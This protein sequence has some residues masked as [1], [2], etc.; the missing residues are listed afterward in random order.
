ML[1]E[2]DL[3][4]FYR[5]SVDLILKGRLSSHEEDGNLVKGQ[6][7]SF[8]RASGFW[9]NMSLTLPFITTGETSYSNVLWRT[10]KHATD[11]R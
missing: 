1:L 7:N 2:V 9:W 10:G 5:Q 11:A 3:Q 6:N 8:A 4:L